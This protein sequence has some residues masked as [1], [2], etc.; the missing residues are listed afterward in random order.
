[1]H[2]A[3]EAAG[4]GVLLDRRQTR[5]ALEVA[6][7]VDLQRQQLA[8]ERLHEARVHQGDLDALLRQ[9]LDRFE[10]RVDGRADRP[11]QPVP[12][13]AQDLRLADRQLPELGVERHADAVAAR[14]AHRRRMRLLHGGREHVLELVLVLRRHDDRVREDPE[15]GVVEQPVVRPA[16]VAGDAAA[17]E[18]ESDRQ[19][20]ETDVVEDLV[21]TALQEGR[22][23]RHDRPHAAEREAAGERHRMLLGDAGVQEA[24]GELLGERNQTG[25]VGHRGGDRDDPRIVL[26]EPDGR[27]AENGGVGGRRPGLP[28]LDPG[29]GIER[30]G[31]VVL[32]RFVLGVLVALALL[33]DGVQQHRAVDLLRAARA[34]RAGR[35]SSA[36]SPD[37]CSGS[38][39]PRT[40]CPA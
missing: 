29:D 35:E 6:E 28:L 4:E 7:L 17:I 26:G 34:L 24:I 9:A 22:V 16:V 18:R 30:R 11:D 36:R 1:M 5:A 13:A 31:A 8:V 37:R 23:D 12:S 20:H 2:R 19:V 14:V 32:D 25:A 27:L 21:E 40:A 38:P 10:R 15:E 39:A 3:A 33:G